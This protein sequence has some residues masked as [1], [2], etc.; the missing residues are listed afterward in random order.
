VINIFK[1]QRQDNGYK[2]Y[3][4]EDVCSFRV[5]TAGSIMMMTFIKLLR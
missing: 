1:K 4:K 5:I 3:W 2:T